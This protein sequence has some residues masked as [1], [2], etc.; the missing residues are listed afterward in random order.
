MDQ[1][2]ALDFE[3]TD[4]E[5]LEEDFQYYSDLFK[6]LHGVRPRGILAAEFRASNEPARID[7]IRNLIGRLSS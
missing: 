5:F 3:A 2:I 4:D 7:I 1:M 6:D